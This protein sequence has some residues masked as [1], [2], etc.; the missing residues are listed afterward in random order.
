[1]IDVL[2]GFAAIGWDFDGTLLN[3]PKSELMHAFIRGHPEKRHVILTFRSHGYQHHM[4]R[5]MRNMYPEAP[6][7]DSF[8]DVKNISNT[9]WEEFDKYARLRMVDRLRGPP[10]HWEEYYT[11]WKG[12][13]CDQLHIPV[14]ID[15]VSAHVLPGCKKYQISYFHPDE[16]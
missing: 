9:A 15:D 2:L 12:M 5:E 8:T 3:H 1:M 7:P 16:L 14:L 6:G 13:M 10:N 11:E 4:F